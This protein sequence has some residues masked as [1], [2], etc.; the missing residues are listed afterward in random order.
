MRD[1]LA[2]TDDELLEAKAFGSACE[3]GRT[4]WA[5]AGSAQEE[6]QSLHHILKSFSHMIRSIQPPSGLSRVEKD[7]F[8]VKVAENASCRRFYAIHMILNRLF[9]FFENFSHDMD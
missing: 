3:G 4:R 9:S 5:E 6:G 8:T 7:G 2:V 1:N